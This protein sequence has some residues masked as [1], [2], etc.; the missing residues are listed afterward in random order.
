[1]RSFLAFDND[2]MSP[3]NAGPDTHGPIQVL[4]FPTGSKFSAS[5]ISLTPF[6]AICTDFDNMNK[7]WLITAHDK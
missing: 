6:S 5:P 2:V 4:H 7:S 3:E 1:M